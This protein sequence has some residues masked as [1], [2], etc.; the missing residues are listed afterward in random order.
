MVVI[1]SPPCTPFSQLQNLSPPSEN[2]RNIL[3]E[4]IRH[5]ELV[6]RL[7]R[8]QVEAGRVFLHEQPA[9]AT[10]WAL[11]IIER[12]MRQVGV[13]VYKADQFMYG[14]KTRGANNHQLVAAKKPTKF[15]TN[16][17]AVGQ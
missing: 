13:D 11:P 2:K 8:K 15:M 12:M 14:L 1:G 10:S 4:G 9:C 16:S 17:R 3:A 7:Y 6:V 5:M